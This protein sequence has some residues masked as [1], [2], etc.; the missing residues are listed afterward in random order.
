MSVKDFLQFCRQFVQFVSNILCCIEAIYFL[1]IWFDC[2]GGYLCYR[3][4][5]QKVLAYTFLNSSEG[6]SWITSLYVGFFWLQ[7]IDAGFNGSW[8]CNFTGAI[9][10][11]HDM[12]TKALALSNPTK[13]AP[14]QANIG[15]L[16]SDVF[17][18]DPDISVKAYHELWWEKHL[19]DTILVPLYN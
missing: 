14:L 1:A 16:V 13:C 11:S 4:F 5:T 3:G 19:R 2:F 17:H 10:A 7:E 12:Q 9:K 15:R 18:P 8:S 6:E